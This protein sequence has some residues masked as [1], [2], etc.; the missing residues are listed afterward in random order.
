LHEK[1]TFLIFKL[2]VIKVRN[3]HYSLRNDPEKRSFQ[4]VIKKKNWMG[5]IK[6]VMNERNVNQSQWED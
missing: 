2:N 3:Y 5:Y 1:L 4:H 6:K